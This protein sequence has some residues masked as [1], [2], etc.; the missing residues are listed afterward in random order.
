MYL[1]K[2]KKIYWLNSKSLS[3][4]SQFDLS[5]LTFVDEWVDHSV[6]M[7][8]VLFV[9]LLV[10][11]GYVAVDLS[12]CPW[13]YCSRVALWIYHT[14][15]EGNLLTE[16]FQNINIQF[17]FKSLYMLFEINYPGSVKDVHVQ[18]F[19]LGCVPVRMYGI[20]PGVN[21]WTSLI[22]PGKWIYFLWKPN[23]SV[24][25]VQ[26]SLYYTFKMYH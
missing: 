20:Q 10:V 8:T 11:L 1:F 26:S 2:K 15:N 24:S 17:S 5:P 23:K 3:V 18:D 6:A 22:G 25:H 16:R 4:S 21:P 14:R 13:G 9:V 12:P 19:T 7:V